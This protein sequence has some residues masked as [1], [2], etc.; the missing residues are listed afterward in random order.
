VLP[1]RAAVDAMIQVAGGLRD[2][3]RALL[4]ANELSWGS[5][6]GISD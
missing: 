4:R 3:F 5:R 2:H 1:G 6:D